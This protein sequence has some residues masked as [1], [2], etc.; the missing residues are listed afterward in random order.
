MPQ[1]QQRRLGNASCDCFVRSDLRDNLQA[2]RIYQ[3]H[4]QSRHLINGWFQKASDL[5]DAPPE[6]SFEPFIFAWFAV[7][8]W[9]ACVM[10]CD[11]DSEIM[12]K[13]IQ[14]QSLNEKFNRLF[15]D[16]I[17]FHMRAT[18]FAECWPIFEVK[19]LKRLNVNRSGEATRREIVNEYLEA[20]AERFEPRCWK[21]HLD[22]GEPCPC[23]WPHTIAAIYRVRCNLFHGEK[24]PYSLIDQTI[25]HSAFRVLVDFFRKAEVLPSQ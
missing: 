16:D 18:A 23:D 5:D 8:A 21:K 4:E 20:G 19:S 12:K 17:E 24:S 13:L 3:L 6:E 2:P 25:V 14:D 9:A 22:L 10:N 11:Q 7:N 15:K 1:H